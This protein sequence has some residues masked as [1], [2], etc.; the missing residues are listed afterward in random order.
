MAEIRKRGAVAADVVKVARIVNCT[1][2]RQDPLAGG[3]LLLRNLR[4]RGAVRPDPLQLGLDVDRTC[5]ILD[6]LGRISERLWAAGPLT[7]G[8]FWEITAVLEIRRQ[9]ADLA[10]HMSENR[11]SQVPT[12]PR[13]SGAAGP[14][15]TGA[16]YPRRKI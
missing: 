14:W 6:R 7:R 5:A 15:K 9:V 1:G 11:R 13:Y 12:I 16:P 10:I 8:A 4:S 2:P 3:S